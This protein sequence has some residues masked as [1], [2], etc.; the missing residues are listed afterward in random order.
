MTSAPILVSRALMVAIN[1]S[2]QQIGNDVLPYMDDPNNEAAVEMSIDAGRL[3]EVDPDAYAEFTALLTE[4][5]YHNTL[6]L[7]AKRV[8]LV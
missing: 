2:W 7:L 1:T 6:A 4:H 3:K 5:G 8:Q